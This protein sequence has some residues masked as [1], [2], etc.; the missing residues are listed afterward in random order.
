MKSKSTSLFRTRS[1]GVLVHVTSL[2][3][4]ESFWCNSQADS[5]G[6]LGKDSFAFVDFMVSAGLKIWQMLP[7]VPTD[8]SPYQALS[9]HAGNPNLISLDNLIARGWVKDTDLSGEE[10]SLAT[11]KATRKNCAQS[12][13]Q[14]ISSQEGAETK[15]AYEKFCADESDWLTD[16]ALFSALHEEHNYKSWMEWPEELRKRDAVKLSEYSKSRKSEIDVYLFEQF[17]FFTQWS[18][19]KKY[20]N[21]KNIFLLGDMPIFVGHDSADVWAQ[22]HYFRLDNDGKAL[23]VAGVPPDFFSA[24]GQSWGNP[25]YAWDVMEADGFQWWLTRLHTQLQL[26]DIVRID[27]FR[28]FDAYWEIPGD[29]RDARQ[30]KW[31]NAPGQA[32]LKACTEKYPNLPLVAENLGIITKNVETLRREFKLP[33]ML[34]LQFAFD[35]KADNPHLPH[36]HRRTDIIYTG[37]HDNDTTLGWYQQLTEDARS[38]LKKYC[39]NNDADIPWLLIRLAFA[40]VGRLAVIPMQ[41]FLGLD[42]SHRMNTPGTST[43][44]WSWKFSWDQVTPELPQRIRESLQLYQRTETNSE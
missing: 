4:F 34:V 11:L 16:F 13:Y 30:G 5:V 17:A 7:V 12:F 33:G 14:Y 26:F 36:N 22:Q 27:H 15:N 39:F 25:H 38:Q 20:A 23:T 40:S 10:R 8:D 35:G 29:T 2:P 42:S 24:D 37:T 9:V 32:L 41:D 28:A 6:T 21:E 44:N 1:A 19:L 18:E 43:K 31:V 3:C